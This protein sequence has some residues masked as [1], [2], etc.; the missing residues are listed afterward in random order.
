[1]AAGDCNSAEF[2]TG[3]SNDCPPDSLAPAGTPCSMGSG[4]GIP[5]GGTSPTCSASGV[6]IGGCRVGDGF[7]CDDHGMGE[8]CYRAPCR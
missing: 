6:C 1:P 5:C 7:C 4:G 2:C 3:S 8:M